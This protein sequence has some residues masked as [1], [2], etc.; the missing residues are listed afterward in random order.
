MT[1]YEPLDTTRPDFPS[2]ADLA[3]MMCRH[4]P[5][6]EQ[7]WYEDDADH[8]HFGSLDP[9]EFQPP[10]GPI[11]EM[12]IRSMA[13][14]LQGYAAL[15]LSDHFDSKIAGL[16]KRVL[17]DRLNRCL[18]WICAHHLSGNKRAE[19]L[20]WDGA[21]GDDW[22]SS[23]WTADMAMAANHVWT[24]LDADVQAAVLRVLAFEADR[25]IDVDPP[26]GRWL[27]TKA[28]ENAWDSYL[29]AWAYCL[30]SDH[31]NADAWL[32]A[33]KRFAVNTFTTD[34]D[35]V[36]TRLLDDRP[37]KDWVC[38]QTAH[39]DLTVEN[40]GSFH[41]GYLGCGGLLLLGRLAFRA[42]GRTPPPHYEHHL[43]DAWQTLRR[44][45]LPNGFTAYPS[46][47]D[48]TYHEPE[49]SLPLAIM[50]EEFGDLMA[51]HML[52]H[53]I[54]YLDESMRYPADGRFNGRMPHAAGGRYF[55]FETGVMGQ[56]GSL[57]MFGMPRLEPL[58]DEE[59]R[60]EKVGTDAYPYV[61]LQVRNSRQ[62]MFSFSWRS[63]SHGVMG[64]VIPAGGEHVLG[65][66]QDAFVGRFEIEGERLKPTPLC[67][68]DHTTDKGFSTTGIVTYAGG[69]IRQSIA[70][71]AL[72]DGETSIVIDRTEVDDDVTLSLNEGLGVYVM[73]DF[74]NDNRVSISFENGR[75]KV[76]GVGGKASVIETGSTWMKVAGCLGVETDGSRLFYEDAAERNTP[77][78]WKS[79]L[80][81]RLF[82][83]PEA[84]D[85]TVRDYACVIRQGSTG[86][87]RVGDG[88]ERLVTDQGD[89][90]AFRFRTRK[91]T[92][93]IV[94][95]FANTQASVNVSGTVIEVQAMDTIVIEE[96]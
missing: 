74:M 12:I 45:F 76:R 24:H 4:I 66:D 75:R 6:I 44:F 28:E 56:L 55:Q 54:R 94:A 32:D 21:W 37:V 59:F 86:T 67:H 63:L 38:T 46:G 36:D 14:E 30:H 80:Q 52:W 42:T 5:Y 3:L 83:C 57:A 84:K 48:W 78:R 65:S 27:D 17:L 81:D 26:D 60:R 31:P 58:S 70:V 47:Q 35:R 95:N 85:G 68:T 40:H 87:R 89:V 13:Q 29:L 50:L 82:L 2:E 33:G 18:R 96:S 49:V 7:Y 88:V 92:A 91:G 25:F 8:G 73:N 22:E 15:Y 64:M 69:R 34:L 19:P 39:P 1:A 90:R 61:W 43:L 10:G 11:N 53:E 93:T 62:G 72:E 51:G 16:E 79:L 77:V 9:E 23:P 20:E 41:P 71:V